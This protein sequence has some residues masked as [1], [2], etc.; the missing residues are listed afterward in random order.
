[1][2][3]AG[4]AAEA[5]GRRGTSAFRR[6][7]SSLGLSIC[8]LIVVFLVIEIGF[9]I[10]APRENIPQREYD[11]HL[12][13]RG[14]PDLECVLNERLFTIG[15]SQNARGFR[16]A[17]RAVEKPSGVTRVLCV[18]DSYTWGWG[19]EQ[20]AIYTAALERRYAEAGSAVEV[21][22]AGVGGYS[23]DQL[24]LYLWDEGFSYSPDFVVYQA[25]WNDVRD[26]PRTLVEAIYAKPAFELGDD[27]A[28]VLQG[29]PVPPLGA[30][31]MLKYF[32][33]RHSRLAYFLKHR[34]H[35]ARFAQ[36]A[37]ETPVPDPRPA[38]GRDEVDYP[39]RLFC[40]LAA[41]MDAECR[42]RGAG[43]VTL[44]DFEVSRAEREHWERFYGHVNVRFVNAYLTARGEAAG[45]PAHIPHDGHWTEDGH[46]W[47]AD[48][49]YD[50]VLRIWN[51]RR[52]LSKPVGTAEIG[53][54]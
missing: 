22:N 47:V 19:V 53:D 5:S 18:G 50:D 36:T 4:S 11:P 45:T 13:W 46:R 21:L 35:L 49:L 28:L 51:M 31:A 20:D 10:V 37:D 40:R 14:R 48:I 7:A 17:E 8:A 26:N 39:F 24:L 43:F 30:T 2:A 42:A 25:A 54:P 12:G 3:A 6:L 29:F 33:S 9:R 23:T 41:E 15:I 34:L 27:G 1:M 32:V 16:D 38:D 52:R 44:I